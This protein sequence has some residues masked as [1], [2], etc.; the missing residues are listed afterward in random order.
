MQYYYYYFLLLLRTLCPCE[1]DNVQQHEF[2]KAYACVPY[3]FIAGA[4]KNSHRLQAYNVHEMMV[5][6]NLEF[7]SPNNAWSLWVSKH[8]CIIHSTDLYE[9][10]TF[11]R[12]ERESK[13]SAINYALWIIEI[14][15]ISVALP[16]RW[17]L[18]MSV[19]YFPSEMTLTVG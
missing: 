6:H 14:T 7:S 11:M 3:W 15:V 16:S 19:S 17:L 13:L 18:F 5:K 1:A 9:L 4:C 2:C 10:L 8:F 12:I